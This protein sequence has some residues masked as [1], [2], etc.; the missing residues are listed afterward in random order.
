MRPTCYWLFKRQLWPQSPKGD[1]MSEF[2]EVGFV[3]IL[4]RGCF[5]NKKWGVGGA[6]RGKL[7]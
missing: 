2:W 5:E 7:T 4:S 6:V 3:L 1:L